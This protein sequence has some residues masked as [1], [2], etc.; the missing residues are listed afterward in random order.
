MQQ[1]VRET[2]NLT[3]IES[4]VEDLV[5]KD[6]NCEGVVLGGKCLHS[7]TVLLEPKLFNFISIPFFIETLQV[8]PCSAVIITTGTFLRGEINIGLR[9]YPAGR[10]GDSPAIGLANTLDRVGFKMKRMKTGNFLGL[11]Q[12]VFVTV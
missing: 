1:K 4:S 10:I 5:I 6:G 2:P 8:L 3:V 7:S 9:T 11:P 12:T